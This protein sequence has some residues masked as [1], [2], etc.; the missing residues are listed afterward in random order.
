MKG[1]FSLCGPLSKIR[2]NTIFDHLGKKNLALAVQ[3]AAQRFASNTAVVAEGRCISYQELWSDIE[4]LSLSFYSI[5]IKSS[6]RVALFVPNGYDFIRCFFALLKIN[7]IVS[8]LNHELTPFELAG[9][10]SNLNPY[11]IIA[12]AAFLERI[13]LENPALLDNRILICQDRAPSF[14]SAMNCFDLRMLH[15]CNAG[16]DAFQND[17]QKTATINYTY[18]GLGYPLGAVLHHDNYLQAAQF[19]IDRTELSES[20]RILLILPSYHVFP[21]MG[22]IISPLLAGASVVI[23]K[24][25]IISHIFDVIKKHKIT[26]LLAVPTLYRMMLSHNRNRDDMQSVHYCITGGDSMPVDMQEELSSTFNTAVLQGYGLTECL[27]V[28]CNPRHANRTGSLGPPGRNDVKIKIV[29]DFGCELR[30]GEIGEIIVSSPTVMSGYYRLHEETKNVL[31]GGWLYTGDYGYLDFGGYLY[32]TGR[33]KKIVKVGGKVV[34]VNE[35]RN[36]LLSHPS[37]ADAVIFPEEDSL[38]GTVLG[39]DVY[40]AEDSDIQENDLNIFCRKHLSRYKIP[41]KINIVTRVLQK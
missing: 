35:V 13:Y 33:K 28:T 6:H 36:V 5:G 38:W 40:P 15:E 22:G 11:A 39:A 29:D 1:Y 25:M 23:A 41:K 34:D 19:Y 37:I 18:G 4:R 9:I 30:P 32:M 31:R 16:S 26:M 14:S 7:V 2:V 24:S 20:H 3:A 17:E 8:P 10:F 27:P 21:L 12:P